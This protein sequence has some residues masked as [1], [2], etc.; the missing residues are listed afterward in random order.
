MILCQVVKLEHWILVEGQDR[1]DV[2]HWVSA[3]PLFGPADQLLVSFAHHLM[4]PEELVAFPKH[5]TL[6]QLILRLPQQGGKNAQPIKVIRHKIVGITYFRE[7]GKC[8][9]KVP[10]HITDRTGL[11]F[12]RATHNHRNTDAVIII[13]VFLDISGCMFLRLWSV[14]LSHGPFDLGVDRKFGNPVLR[15]DREWEIGS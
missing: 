10:G 6:I 4:E 5:R 3:P 7:C 14:I 15:H 2:A 9:G 13:F 1:I 12:L 11:N 8:I